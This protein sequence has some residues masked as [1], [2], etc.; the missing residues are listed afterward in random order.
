LEFLLQTNFEP[1][2]VQINLDPLTEVVCPTDLQASPDLI[3]E[4][5]GTTVE[6]K[7]NAR[8]KPK[9]RNFL[10]SQAYFI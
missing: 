4:W 5:A 10:I 7:L 2:F 1:D 3:A 6:T 8:T 9:P